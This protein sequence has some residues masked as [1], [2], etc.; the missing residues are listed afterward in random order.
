[1]Q[2]DGG[3]LFGGAYKDNVLKGNGGPQVSGWEC[4]E[5]GPNVRATILNCP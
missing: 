5:T 3:G 2:S 1:V 4:I